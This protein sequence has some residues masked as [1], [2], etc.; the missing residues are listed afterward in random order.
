MACRSLCAFR[1]PAEFRRK[2][3][4]GRLHIPG[5]LEGAE[6]P[7]NH[8]RWRV[9]PASHKSWTRLRRGPFFP[10][11]H[12]P[13]IVAY[14]MITKT[15]ANKCWILERATFMK[16]IVMVKGTLDHQGCSRSQGSQYATDRASS[17]PIKILRV[18]KR[19]QP[20]LSLRWHRLESRFCFACQHDMGS[21]RGGLP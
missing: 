4:S 12:Q 1:P 19:G 10:T 21:S 7:A 9:V 15:K 18:G 16:R 6:A 11:N 17:F 3:C 20:L 5:V 2:I 8:R 13:V 14:H